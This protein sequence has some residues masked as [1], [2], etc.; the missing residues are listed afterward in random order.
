MSY[1]QAFCPAYGTG[2]TVAPAAGSANAALVS[3]PRQLRVMNTGASVGYF[4]TYSS[5]AAAD[6]ASAGVATANDFAVPPGLA[7]TVTKDLSHDRWAF[8]SDVGTT[9]L[10]IQG[11]GM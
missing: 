2:Q 7:A 8:V 3:G 10:L 5:K 6:K 4:R 1:T 9:F 11:E